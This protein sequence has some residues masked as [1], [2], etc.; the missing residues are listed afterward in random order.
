MAV[1]KGVRIEFKVMV[2]NMH[3]HDDRHDEND[4]ISDT[5]YNQLMVGIIILFFSS[6]WSLS[7]LSSSIK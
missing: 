6:F 7:T 3:H 5:D 2:L 4:V 1:K